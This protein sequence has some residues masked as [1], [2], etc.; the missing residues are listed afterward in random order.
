MNNVTMPASVYERRLSA[1]KASI[2][3]ALHPIPNMR[4][5]SSRSSGTGPAL[6][7]QPPDELWG[8]GHGHAHT[9]WH[10]EDLVHSVRKYNHCVEPLP[11]S[12]SGGLLAVDFAVW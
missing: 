9:E 10:E 11:S 2:D 5:G 8:D 6:H 12:G 7:S 3:I 1:N 4:C